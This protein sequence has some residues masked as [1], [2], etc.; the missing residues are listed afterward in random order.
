[1]KD[2]GKINCFLG[3]QIGQSKSKIEMDQSRYLLSI[4][5]KYDVWL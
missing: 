2:M 5:Q 3:I 4:L 1:M